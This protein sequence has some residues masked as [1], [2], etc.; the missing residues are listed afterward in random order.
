MSRASNAFSN[1]CTY[2]LPYCVTVLY[3]HHIARFSWHN[4]RE[5]MVKPRSYMLR[6]L[7]SVYAMWLLD[8]EQPV[9]RCRI[10]YVTWCWLQLCRYVNVPNHKYP[11]L[12]NDV[13]SSFCYLTQACA[14]KVQ[15]DNSQFSA[16]SEVG[17]RLRSSF[18]Y[19]WTNNQSGWQTERSLTSKGQGEVTI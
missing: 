18:D 9:V 6:T 5:N 17:S 12:V 11:K 16:C 15:S 10:N 2:D 19:Y 8:F 7:K 14:C 3:D 4:N 13:R 1:W